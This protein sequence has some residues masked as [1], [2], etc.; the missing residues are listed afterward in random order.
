MSQLRGGVNG[1]Y[2]LDNGP[3]P[4]MIVTILLAHY[5]LLLFY[6]S[7]HKYIRYERMCVNCALLWYGYSMGCCRT[8]TFSQ[9]PWWRHQMKPF[10]VLL[11]LSGGIHQSPVHS[12]HKGQW[13]GALMFSLIC[14]WTNGWAN[15]RDAGDLR[16]HRA[17]YNVTVMIHSSV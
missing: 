1:I 14:A 8:S 4:G 3:S 5:T 6:W 10:S 7:P 13:R 12:P 16:R 17:H 11:G 2:R 15:N 9:E